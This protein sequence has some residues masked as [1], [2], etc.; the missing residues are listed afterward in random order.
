MS[1][2]AAMPFRDSKGLLWERGKRHRPS[3]GELADRFAERHSKEVRHL[4]ARE[5]VRS[6]PARKPQ[7]IA[8]RI[9]SRR[10]V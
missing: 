9:V 8:W 4:V 10:L 1:M 2:S 7:W 6:L 5:R 3:E